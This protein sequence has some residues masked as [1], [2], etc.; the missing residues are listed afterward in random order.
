MGKRIVTR[1]GS[2]ARQA[3]REWEP[4][5]HHELALTRDLVCVQDCT[6]LDAAPTDPHQDVSKGRGH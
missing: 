6:A 5:G 2:D 1:I 3:T 4:D